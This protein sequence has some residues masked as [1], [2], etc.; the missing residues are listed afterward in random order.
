[1]VED[2]DL[3]VAAVVYVHVFLY[4][5][6]R[7][8]DPPCGA[9]IIWKTV[10]SLDPNVVFEVSHFIEGLD[11]VA[12]SVTDIDQAVVA[13]DHTMH[14]LHERATHTRIN[15]FFCPLMPPR[16]KEFPGSIEN[17]YAAITITVSHIDV[18]IG[19]VYRYVG[20]LR[21]TRIQCPALASDGATYSLSFS[22]EYPITPAIPI[23]SNT[24]HS[25]ILIIALL[26]HVRESSQ[27]HFPLI[28]VAKRLV[29]SVNLQLNRSQ[30]FPR[31]DAEAVNFIQI[32]LL[33]HRTDA[34]STPPF[35]CES[36]MSLFFSTK[37]A[38][39]RG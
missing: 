16:T 32:A 25:F 34:D 28:L 4:P 14:N 26:S 24:Q 35:F 36:Q 30:A 29:N 3:L 21:V 12:L 27:T 22:C 11:P 15:L 8:A 19:G 39:R 17:S 9:P 31:P 10:L 5:A 13:D 6:G 20:K 38:S 7:K 23:N 2:L 1:M 18:A 33:V 37:L